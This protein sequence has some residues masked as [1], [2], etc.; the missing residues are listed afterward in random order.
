LAARASEIVE[1][2]AEIRSGDYVFPG[3]RHRRPISNPSLAS[4]CPSGATIH[5]FRSS[6]RDWVSEEANYPRELAEEALAHATGSSVERA[7]RR[8]D[9]L[10]KR[11]TRWK[12]GR[13]IASRPRA[14]MWSRLPGP[15]RE[16][17]NACG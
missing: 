4:L 2:M 15:L 10:E 7:Y 17:T 16:L 8:G 5:G 12:H 1:K 9:A 11:R 3:R 6:F 14:G 13:D